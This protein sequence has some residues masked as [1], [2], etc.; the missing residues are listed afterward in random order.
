MKEAI[1]MANKHMKRC[2]TSQVIR[3][4]QNKTTIRHHY[5]LLRVMLGK[6]EGERGGGRG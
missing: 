2:S 5:K 3:E 4:M 6:T 1:Q